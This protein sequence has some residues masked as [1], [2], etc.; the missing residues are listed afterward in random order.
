MTYSTSPIST[1]NRPS[2]VL[3]LSGVALA[4]LSAGVL[5]GGVAS[6]IPLIIIKVLLFVLAIVI[7][8]VTVSHFKRGIIWS[9]ILASVAAVCGVGGL[10][11]GWLWQEFGASDAVILFRGGPVFLYQYLVDLSADYT[12]GMTR[13]GSSLDG[14]PGMT[15][16]I[17]WGQTAL[18]AITPFLSAFFGRQMNDLAQRVET[19]S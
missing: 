10:W 6:M 5:Y 11:F 7:V 12:Y 14:G 3:G 9:L 1:E 8:G 4:G 15:Q 17:W 18:F 2:F 16:F 13:R 19:S